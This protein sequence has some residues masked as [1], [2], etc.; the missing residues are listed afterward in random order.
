MKSSSLISRI[1]IAVVLTL[2]LGVGGKLEAQTALGKVPLRWKLPTNNMDGTPATDLAGAK[3][4]YGLSSSNYTVVV[5]V[6]LTN[7]CV[8]TGLVEGVTYY[9]TGTAY[10]KDGL[11]SDFCSEVA[12]VA[13][14]NLLYP[15]MGIRKMLS[16]LFPHRKDDEVVLFQRRTT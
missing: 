6:G 16:Y 10:N 13:R 8:I 5:D 11:E 1:V 9:W 14:R 3:I 12:K 15:P 4:Y 2:L 7:H